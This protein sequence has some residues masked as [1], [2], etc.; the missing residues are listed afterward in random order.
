MRRTIS[1]FCYAVGLAILQGLLCF[2]IAPFAR[3]DGQPL[4]VDASIC[5]IKQGIISVKMPEST[6]LKTQEQAL[7]T[8]IFSYLGMQAQLTVA[9]DYKKYRLILF[10]QLTPSRESCSAQPGEKSES[11][12][13]CSEIAVVDHSEPRQTNFDS[14]CFLRIRHM[15]SNG[16]GIEAVLSATDDSGDVGILLH[17]LTGRVKSMPQEINFSGLIKMGCL[18][19]LQSEIAHFIAEDGTMKLVLRELPNGVITKSDSNV[20]KNEEI[21]HYNWLIPGIALIKAVTGNKYLVLRSPSF[22]DDLLQL[23]IYSRRRMGKLYMGIAVL[24]SEDIEDSRMISNMKVKASW[25][26]EGQTPMKLFDIKTSPRLGKK[27]RVD[28]G[29]GSNFALKASSLIGNQ[30]YGTAHDPLVNTEGRETSSP[31]SQ[32]ATSW[33]DNYSVEISVRSK[34]IKSDN[35]AETMEFEALKQN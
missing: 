33:K 3:A 35:I 7:Q 26:T 24:P 2:V 8:Q 25:I 6:T 34:A 10:L 9:A 14:H 32:V 30:S 11:E 4:P 27:M 13:P 18:E 22:H 1:F 29:F 23:H 12:T 15:L 16:V 19:T 17:C 20:I 21:A 28:I 31:Y 5:K